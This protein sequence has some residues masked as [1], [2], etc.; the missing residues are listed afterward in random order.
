MSSSLVCI[1]S[2]SGGGLDYKCWLVPGRMPLPALYWATDKVGGLESKSVTTRKPISSQLQHG[3]L[4]RAA[5]IRLDCLVLRT[6]LFSHLWAHMSGR[7][8]LLIG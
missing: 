8:G 2:I 6:K 1:S 3:K 4:I 5:L 7:I